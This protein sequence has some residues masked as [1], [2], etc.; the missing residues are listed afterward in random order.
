MLFELLEKLEG[1]PRGDS[2]AGRLGFS[3]RE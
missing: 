3:Y 1:D 2:D